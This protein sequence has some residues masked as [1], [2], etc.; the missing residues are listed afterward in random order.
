MKIPIRK[1]IKKDLPNVLELIKE[2][3]DFEK[4]RDQV[5]IT[6]EDREKD[7]FGGESLALVLSCRKRQ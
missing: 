4:A 7:G 1:G 3:A 5:T 2:L 6:L